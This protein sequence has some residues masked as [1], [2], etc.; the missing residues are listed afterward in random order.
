M[1]SRLSVGGNAGKVPRGR[2]IKLR[3]AAHGVG[4]K[5]VQGMLEILIE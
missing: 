3:V 1:W 5:D 2:D 4:G